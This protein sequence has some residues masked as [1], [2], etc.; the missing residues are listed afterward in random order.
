MRCLIAISTLLF[1]AF[2]I[3]EFQYAAITV[4][5]N[6]PPDYIPQA[7][8]SNNPQVQSYQ[9]KLENADQGLFEIKTEHSTFYKKGNGFQGR[10]AIT[11]SLDR[12][13]KAQY[14]FEVEAQDQKGRMVETT[15]LIIQ[16]LDENDNKPIIQNTIGQTYD[17]K[18]STSG[19]Q[20]LTLSVTDLD[21]NDHIYGKKGF[22]FKQP[23]N[24]IKVGLDNSEEVIQD[25]EVKN[26]FEMT[27]TGILKATGL[28][29]IDAEQVKKFYMDL[30][31]RDGGAGDGVWK[32]HD[33][34]IYRA[35][36][37]VVDKNDNKPKFTKQQ[38]FT[39]KEL[40]L[41]D[42]FI[43]NI[44][45]ED[46][47]ITAENRESDYKVLTDSDKFKIIANSEKETVGKLMVANENLIDF[48]SLPIGKK[49]YDIQIEA[50]N[51]VPSSSG[52]YK[53]GKTIR[54]Q[55]EDENECPVFESLEEE[56]H[57][58]TENKPEDLKTIE[59]KAEDKDSLT[60]GN[61][62]RKQS[63]T[64][65]LVNDIRN[66]FSINSETGVIKQKK[67]VDREAAGVNRNS[68][69][70]HYTIQVKV[71]DDFMPK[72]CCSKNVTLNILD[73]NDNAPQFYSDNEEFKQSQ[74]VGVCY[75][76]SSKYERKI[77]NDVEWYDL[78]SEVMIADQD[79]LEFGKP[80]KIG[81]A[82]G[83]SH[84]EDFMLVKDES[85]QV[86]GN[87]EKYVLMT[88]LY[89][90]PYGEGTGIALRVNMADKGGQEATRVLNINTCNCPG[91]QYSCEEQLV[92][93]AGTNTWVVLVIIILLIF[94]G[95]IVII[96]LVWSH[97]R[98][99][100][101]DR[102]IPME[103]DHNPGTIIHYPVDNEDKNS[104]IEFNDIQ[105]YTRK[106]K[107]VPGPDPAD[108]SEFIRNAKEQADNDPSAPPYDSLLTFDYE[109][110]G[111]T[112]GSLSSLCSA[113]TDQ[114]VDYNY[115]HEWGPRFQKLAEIY[116]YEDQD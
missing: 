68:D 75:D 11:K 24:L 50:S 88:K 92:G 94:I 32:K 80:F 37:N 7:I 66:Y 52:I 31:V 72:A 99:K 100:K 30:Q 60:V 53:V 34:D 106:P 17:V 91:S 76:I 87:K 48:E 6:Q 23:R 67:A 64:Y 113:T 42:F 55:V 35:E 57:T 29:K 69:P 1:N 70:A 86:S 115:L 27:K 77:I 103:G 101:G 65:E 8:Y 20:V 107:P 10:I 112:A 41:K 105:P 43:G 51:R 56:I 95:M 73:E 4:R 13:T 98:N 114:S 59:I 97:Q 109:G 25:N 90:L 116:T 89:R 26:Y 81:M 45:I 40:S 16:V 110:A 9:L 33:S 3:A 19:Y 2:S 71:C 21:K 5:E 14:S 28:S 62:P 39:V 104:D 44:T 102:L 36:V 85:Y 12:E 108:V 78:K 54:I 111:S 49:Y 38:T 22:V 79:G 63:V 58:T 47:D 93:A 82:E 83:E 46:K 74:T 18:E 61:P 96:V 15:Q 84:S